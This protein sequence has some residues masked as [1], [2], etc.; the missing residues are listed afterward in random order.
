MKF[1]TDKA[2]AYLIPSVIKTLRLL[3][4]AKAMGDPRPYLIRYYLPVVITARFRIEGSASPLRDRR[5]GKDT[6]IML[7]SGVSGKIRVKGNNINGKGN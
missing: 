6:M 7:T 1:L 3:K 5:P 4:M 2:V